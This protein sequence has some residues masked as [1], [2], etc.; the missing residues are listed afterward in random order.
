MR[1][2]RIAS[3]GTL[4]AAAICALALPAAD[5]LFGQVAGKFL[6]GRAFERRLASPL[7]GS[8]SGVPLGEVTAGLSRTQNVAIALDRRIDPGQPVSLDFSDMPLAEVLDVLAQDQNLDLFLLGP[9][10]C[11]VPRG[12]ASRLETVAQLRRHE[13]SRR[14]P[15]AGRKWRSKAPLVWDDLSAPAELLTDLSK[16][17]GFTIVNPQRLP[18]DLWAAGNLPRLAL[19]DRL[20]FIL[21]QFGLTYEMSA[22]AEADSLKK[23]LAQKGPAIRLVPIPDTPVSARD[24]PA[25]KSADR[26]INLAKKHKKRTPAAGKGEI[27]IEKFSVSEARLEPLLRHLATRLGLTLE[28]DRKAIVAAGIRLDQRVSLNVAGA[29]PDELF[30]KILGPAGLSAR[31]NGTKIIIGPLKKWV[32]LQPNEVEDQRGNHGH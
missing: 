32:T 1:K 25:A 17:G 29:T 21:G 2:P 15:A 12:E 4:I 9:V 5:G 20:S 16:Q 13:V 7:G 22:E 11:L 23:E 3:I 24:Y 30:K 18:H 19:A 31:R 28:L 14:P 26:L 8:W 10:V 27:R 6:E